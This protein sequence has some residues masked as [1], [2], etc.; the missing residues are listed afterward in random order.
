MWISTKSSIGLGSRPKT[1]ACKRKLPLFKHFHIIQ[2]LK[3]ICNKIESYHPFCIWNEWNGFTGVH[4]NWTMNLLVSVLHTKLWPTLEMLRHH[5][6]EYASHIAF[7]DVWRSKIPPHDHVF[8]PWTTSFFLYISLIFFVPYTINHT[9]W[10]INK[11][12][13]KIIKIKFEH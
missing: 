13:V 8:P 5:I 1:I 4:D 10:Y 7:K 6:L 12:S 11:L 9:T 2:H 3:K